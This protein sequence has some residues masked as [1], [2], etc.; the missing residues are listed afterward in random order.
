MTDLREDSDTPCTCEELMEEYI[1]LEDDLEGEPE[2]EQEDAASLTKRE[3][4]ERQFARFERNYRS[5]R[6][7]ELTLGPFIKKK[8]RRARTRKIPV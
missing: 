6:I 1:L 3:E 8:S 5:R 7:R 4:I 2:E